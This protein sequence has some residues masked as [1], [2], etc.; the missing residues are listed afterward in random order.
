TGGNLSGYLILRIPRVTADD[1]DKPKSQRHEYWNV[2]IISKNSTSNITVTS[3]ARRC[4][5]AMLSK[6]S[7]LLTRAAA[8]FHSS[9][10]SVN[11]QAVPSTAANLASR[12]L[13]LSRKQKENVF[14]LNKEQI[15]LVADEALLSSVVA[16]STAW[17]HSA[18]R[19]L[20][21]ASAL[22]DRVR[23]DIESIKQEC[24]SQNK[25]V[26]KNIILKVPI[27]GTTSNHEYW[28]ATLVFTDAGRITCSVSSVTSLRT[29]TDRA[30]ASIELNKVMNLVDSTIV[31]L[32]EAAQP[33][34]QTSPQTYPIPAPFDQKNLLQARWSSD[35][36]LKF[37]IVEPPKKSTNSVFHFFRSNLGSWFS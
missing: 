36:V 35:D 19:F 32:D 7:S 24:L 16:L 13:K 23:K 2:L 30:T 20:F 37:T 34:P 17:D 1:I 25:C 4:N 31:N 15:Q 5:P 3:S 14:S 21:S 27:V 26:D 12:E 22:N 8:A 18:N 10:P 28:N 33:Q 11:V 6:I 9:E 29:K